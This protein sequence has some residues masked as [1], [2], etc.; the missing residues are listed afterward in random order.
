MRKIILSVLIIVAYILI[1]LY[2]PYAQHYFPRI[3]LEVFK[4]IIAGALLAILLLSKQFRLSQLKAQGSE[5]KAWLR[6]PL[7]FAGLFFVSMFVTYLVVFGAEYLRVP[8]VAQA[9][10]LLLVLCGTVIFEEVISR[11]FLTNLLLRIWRRNAKAISWVVLLAG[12]IFGVLHY[13]NYRVISVVS[14][15]HSVSA[16]LIGVYFCAAF[17]KTNS[18]STTI[19]LHAVVNFPAFL[20]ALL[21]DTS[22]APEASVQRA[23]LI[24]IFVLFVLSLPFVVISIKEL[25]KKAAG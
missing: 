4:L 3:N 25:R 1:V 7:I 18:L 2:F 11:A 16:S 24:M 17:M 19:L 6:Y 15:L 5:L 10:D 9:A 20:L 13:F 23:S 12:V 14:V 8:S 21:F 22:I